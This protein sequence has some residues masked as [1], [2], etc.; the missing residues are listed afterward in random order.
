MDALCKTLG[1]ICR[2]KALMPWGSDRKHLQEG[3]K[4]VCCQASQLCIHC[5]GWE[6]EVKRM[7]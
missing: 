3:E 7:Y 6:I 2:P 5:F 4:M 1:A